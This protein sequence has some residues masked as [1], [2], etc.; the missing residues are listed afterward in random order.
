MHFSYL[1]AC[2]IPNTS[3][4]LISLPQQYFTGWSLVQRSPTECGVSY[5]CDRETSKNEEAYGL[6]RH[7]K[8]KKILGEEQN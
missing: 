8:K 3:L 4:V 1:H 6:S 7:K 5:Q 2:Y